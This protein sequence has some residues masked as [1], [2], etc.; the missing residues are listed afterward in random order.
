MKYFVRPSKAELIKTE[1][2]ISLIRQFMELIDERVKVLTKEKLKLNA[3][4]DTKRA[5]LAKYKQDLKYLADKVMQ[6]YG[7]LGLKRVTHFSKKS[8][9]INLKYEYLAGIKYFFPYLASND[10][11]YP[12]SLTN[13]E[14]DD[15]AD[16]T[17]VFL[18]NIIDLSKYIEA[19]KRI[20]H[21]L[22]M[23]KRKLN[24]L[25]NIILPEL[26]QSKNQIKKYLME[27]E[28]FNNVIKMELINR[29]R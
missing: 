19:E 13:F 28:R 4:I 24:T 10:E 2:E 15:L 20:S 18:E 22:S 29:A 8:L 7:Y 6:T 11:Q 12:L 14:I 5:K 16:T 25:K 17:K 3:I 27:K 21:E 9:T 26:K 1:E 23:I